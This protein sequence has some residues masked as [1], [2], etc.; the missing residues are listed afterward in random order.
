MVD[1]DLEITLSEV[2]NNFLIDQRSNRCLTFFDL[3]LNEDN[4]GGDDQ[5]HDSDLSAASV[6]DDVEMLSE[7]EYSSESSY[8]PPSSDDDETPPKKN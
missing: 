6:D 3:D 4:L 7:Q 8:D 5:N 1:Q 2:R